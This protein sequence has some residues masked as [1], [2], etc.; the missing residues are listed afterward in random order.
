MKL[1][2][3]GTVGKIVCFEDLDYIRLRLKN[4]E[5]GELSS[6]YVKPN[7][8]NNPDLYKDKETEVSLEKV[9][10]EDEPSSL[11]EW[12]SMHYKDF[13][14]DIEFVTDKSPEGT[15]FLKGFSGLGGF[16][17]YKI[18]VDNFI[19]EEGEYEEEDDDFI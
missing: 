1:I 14:C 5:T 19:F 17:R 8:V 2:E 13:G 10:E 7:Q 6:A 11:P 12:L 9:E 18:D 3:S 16:L 4:S 15:Q